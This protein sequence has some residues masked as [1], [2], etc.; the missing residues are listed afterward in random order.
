[1]TL[2]YRPDIDGLRAVSVLL[3][4]GFHYSPIRIPGGFI[5]VDVFFVISGFLIT[6]IVLEQVQNRTFSFPAFLLRRARRLFPALFVVLLCALVFAWFTLHADEM[7]QFSSHLFGAAFYVLNFFLI[8]ER[9]Y[10]EIGENFRPLLHLWSLAI[11][12]QFYLIWPLLICLIWKAPGR[13]IVWMFALML[14]SITLNYWIAQHN[15]SL[16]FYLLPTRAWE[17]LIGGLLA[18]L[19]FRQDS[20]NSIAL[21][22][23][24]S[25]GIG[26][27]LAS[28]LSLLGLAIIL[29]GAF[30]IDSGQDLAGMYAIVPVLGACLVIAAPSASTANRFFLSQ[31]IL[32]EIGKFSYPLY[33][34]HWVVLSFAALGQHPSLGVRAQLVLLSLVLGWLTYRL[35]EKPIRSRDPKSTGLVSSGLLCVLGFIGLAIWLQDGLPERSAHQRVAAQVDQLEFVV[36][37][38]HAGDCK[39]RFPSS[40]KCYLSQAG[41]PAVV[42]IGDSHAHHLYPGLADVM[43]ETGTTIALLTEAGCPPFLNVKSIHTETGNDWCHARNEHLRE[44][45]NDPNV[46]TVV[47]AANWHLYAK[48]HRFSDFSMDG[49]SPKIWNIAPRDSGTA[50]SMEDL[51]VEKLKEVVLYFQDAG[52]KVVLIKQAPELSVSLRACFSRPLWTVDFMGCSPDLTAVNSYLGQY[53]ELVNRALDGIDKVEV[54]DPVPVLC[55]GDRCSLSRDGKLLYRDSVHLTNFGS[56]LLARA[57]I[58]RF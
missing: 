13:P 26:R 32:V 55:E 43:N 44:I 57:W 56:D 20:E 49:P 19:Y 5:G 25:S 42:L 41:Q 40:P 39:A 46:E 38:S 1:M 15:A 36:D 31:P 50:R 35:I 37:E 54:L 11:E 16:A 17:L 12:E 4:V 52:K 3:V 48:G 10:F 53:T 29:A 27:L 33:L 28:N 58:G 21:R 14:S 9:D 23:L 45:R 7:A 2:R 24:G 22:L 47:L 18:V 8:S 51:F 34:W 30:L 6:G